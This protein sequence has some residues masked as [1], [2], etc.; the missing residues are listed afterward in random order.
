M[1]F[2]NIVYLPCGYNRHKKMLVFS[3]RKNAELSIK[4]RELKDC[5]V[6]QIY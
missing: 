6:K 3:S 5:Y 2:G 4:F 1:N